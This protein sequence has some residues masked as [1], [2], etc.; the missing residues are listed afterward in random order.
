MKPTKKKFLDCEH[1]CRRTKTDKLKKVM[2][3]IT[4]SVKAAAANS[5]KN[6]SPPTI[7]KLSKHLLKWAE[8]NG[9]PAKEAND[10]NT[11]LHDN[12]K[13]GESI[14]GMLIASWSGAGALPFLHCH[15]WRCA[16]TCA[17]GSVS[18]GFQE[19]V[20]SFLYLEFY[21]N[22]VAG[23][24]KPCALVCRPPPGTKHTHA[25][26]NKFMECEQNC[27]KEKAEKIKELM[28]PK[29]VVKAL[30]QAKVSSGK[31]HA[32]VVKPAS[33]SHEAQDTHETTE[34]AS[35]TTPDA[36]EASKVA[37]SATSSATPSD[38]SEEN[39]HETKE[40]KLLKWAEKHGLPKKMADDP[41]DKTKVRGNLGHVLCCMSWPPLLVIKGGGGGFLAFLMFLAFILLACWESLFL[42]AKFWP[43]RPHTS[44]H[45]HGFASLTS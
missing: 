37:S 15:P 17:G 28:S 9:L 3:Q 4:S 7:Q 45:A 11:N 22:T 19:C 1:L 39:S 41:A 10:A 8:L 29:N 42:L 34:E 32:S 33:H 2:G 25:N 35:S 43:S 6:L 20:G 26:F 40:E 38:Q 44:L 16:H 14:T 30:A 31:A 27:R 36:H 18:D 21:L 13:V 5:P 12:E 24:W 23:W